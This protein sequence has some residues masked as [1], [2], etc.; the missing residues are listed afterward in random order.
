MAKAIREC[1]L[2]F[3]E[4]EVAEIELKMKADILQRARQHFLDKGWTDEEIDERVKFC[5]VEQKFLFAEFNDHVEHMLF[6]VRVPVEIKE[7]L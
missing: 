6:E 1:D 7:E 5:G 3:D 2:V 4:V